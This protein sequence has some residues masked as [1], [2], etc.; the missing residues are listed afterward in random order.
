MCLECMKGIFRR[1]GNT[2]DLFHIAMHIIMEMD[3]KKERKKRL[4]IKLLCPSQIQ[5]VRLV[6]F[7]FTNYKRLK[8]ICDVKKVPLVKSY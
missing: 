3:D 2:F 4:C 8:T 5:M 6:L 7:T 1:K